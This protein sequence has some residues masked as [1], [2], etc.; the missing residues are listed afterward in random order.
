M[1]RL[2][3][4]HHQSWL[5]TIPPL[6]AITFRPSWLW[7]ARQHV[8]VAALHVV[9]LIFPALYPDCSR[10]MHAITDPASYWSRQ[11]GNYF[12]PHLATLALVYY[13]LRVQM[14][15][16]AARLLATPEMR[17]KLRRLRRLARPA[18]ISM[19]DP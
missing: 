19:R 1:S 17:S 10:N 4:V 9:V 7:L 11:A 14:D 2:G 12:L 8:V 16:F 18:G 3:F 15:S 6:L 13:L 5:I